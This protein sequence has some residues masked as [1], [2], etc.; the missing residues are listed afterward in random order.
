[1]IYFIIFHQFRRINFFQVLKSQFSINW[2]KLIYYIN[3]II[4]SF[5]IGLLILLL[6]KLGILLLV[7]L[8]LL[9]ECRKLIF[10]FFNKFKLFQFFLEMFYLFIE[11]LLLLLLLVLIQLL[12]KYFIFLSGQFKVNLKS[13]IKCV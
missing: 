3:K 2:I 5:Q 13:L 8:L 1:M 7:F 12:A 6:R 10:E 4:P 9:K 11:M